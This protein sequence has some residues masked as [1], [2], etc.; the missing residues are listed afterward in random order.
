MLKLTRLEQNPIITPDPSQS[1]QAKATFNGNVLAE[2]KNIHLVFRALSDTQLHLGKQL[3][4][5]SIG[6][7][8]STDGIAFGTK[9][10][11]ISPDQEWDQFGCEDPRLTKIDDQYFVFYTAL[12]EYPFSPAKIRIGVAVFSNFETAPIKHLVTPFNS[13]AMTLFPERINNQYVAL[14]TFNT[15]LPPAH[16]GLAV[17]DKLDDI[18]S[19]SYWQEWYRQAASHTLPIERINSDQIEVGATPILLPEGWLVI[20]AHIRHYPTPEKRIFGI[21]ALLL[22]RNDP[23][24]IIARTQDFLMQAEEQY[25]TQG[26]INQVVFPSGAMIK[27]N[28]LFIYYGAADTT[29][30][31][32]SCSLPDL[33]SVLDYSKVIVPK[34]KRLNTQ[35]LLSPIS[36]HEWE[37]KAVFNPAAYDDGEHF[38]LIYRAMSPD[39]TSVF[40]YARTADGKTIEDRSEMPIYVP[41]IEAEVK[42]NVGGNSG[43]EDPRLTL[44]DNKLYMCYTAYDGVHSPRVALTSIFLD[45]FLKKDFNWDEP[46]LISPPGI[47]DKDAT[48]FPEKINGKYMIIHRIQNAIVLDT[49]DSLDFDGKT[50]WLRTLAYISARETYWDNDKIGACSAPLRTDLG[51]LLFYHGVSRF[52]HEYRVGAMLLKLDD[53]AIVLARTDWPILEAIAPYEKQGIVKNVVFPCSVILRHDLLYF[54]YGGADTVVS[55]ATLS[56]SVLLNYLKV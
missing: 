45:D 3:Q 9:R 55:S 48:I 49:V 35:P 36:I 14:L 22:D 39:N 11:L 19:P 20:Y 6:Y 53:P 43:C 15:D 51:W 54:F 47:D 31:V 21:E 23:A 32:A 17:F 10:Q 27:D 50:T 8:Q 29:C 33:L 2:E 42:K 34:V 12:G 44:I 56:L 25:E 24:K 1:W 30:C 13:K 28:R 37:A 40:G 41:R 16:I 26:M 52:S 18:W 5:S 7:T 46:V 4:I 38:H